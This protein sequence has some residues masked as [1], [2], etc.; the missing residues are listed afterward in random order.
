[1]KQH[2]RDMLYKLFFKID[3]LLDRKTKILILCYHSIKEDSFRFSVNPIIF[4]QQL[5]YLTKSRNFI[6]IDEL[7][8]FL[9][10]EQVLPNYS[11]LLTFDDGYKDL[12]QI[13]ALLAKHNIQPLIFVHP[14]N[15]IVDYDELG[16]RY[17]R[18]NNADLNLLISKGWAVGSHS[19]THANLPTLNDMELAK[20]I[21]ESKKTLETDLGV[22][23]K[24]FS[25]PKGKYDQRIVKEVENA[26]YEL[27]FSMDDAIITKKAGK[28]T[29]PRIG[30]DRTHDMNSFKATISPSNILFRKFIKSLGFTG[31]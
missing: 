23:I 29:L 6:N 4:E 16:Q 21:T 27:A 2:I 15:A 22:T 5:D 25:Y 30:V 9:K 17:E 26:G 18:L 28:F 8:G 1:M 31:L 19:Y 24:Y 13:Q 3:L 7:L 20:E 11:V 12:V 14:Q 10:G